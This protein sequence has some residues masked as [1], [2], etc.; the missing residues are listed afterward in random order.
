MDRQRSGSKGG[1][2]TVKRHGKAHMSE[3]GKKGHEATIARH[4]N[5]DRDGY[6]R[7][8]RGRAAELGVEGFVDKLMRERLEQGEKIVCEELPVL[9][10][11]DDCPW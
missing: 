6:H 9:S 4:F 5:G 3:I 7:Y 8:L 11:P 2:E 1:R 10:D